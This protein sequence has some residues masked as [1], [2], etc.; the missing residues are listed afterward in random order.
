[1]ISRL[2]R[3]FKLILLDIGMNI[4]CD[5]DGKLH[6]IHWPPL[7]VEDSVAIL[8][9]LEVWNP[10]SF[11]WFKSWLEKFSIFLFFSFVVETVIYNGR[12]FESND[13]CSMS[14]SVRGSFFAHRWFLLLLFGCILFVILLTGIE[15]DYS[16][17]N[18]RQK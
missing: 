14:T 11:Y 1:M 10:Y 18:N 4:I 17:D 16:F 7:S 12:N 2:I 15:R 5:D 8:Q 3:E 9:I 6:I 13:S